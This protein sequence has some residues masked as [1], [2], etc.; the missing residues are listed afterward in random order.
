MPTKEENAKAFTLFSQFKDTHKGLNRTV[1]DKVLLVDGLNTF[2][3]C[4]S[5]NPMMNEDGLHTGGVAGFLKSVGYAIKFF[6]PTRCIIIFDGDGGSAVRR[7]IYPEYKMKRKS[8]VRLNRTYA[9]LSDKDSE[10]ASKA[11]QLIRLAEYLQHLPVNI[12]IADG[13]EADDTIAYCATEYFKD[14]MVI[15][16]SSD[17][18]FLQLVSERIKVWSPS[19]KTVYG[20]AEVLRDYGIHPA[21]FALFRAMDGDASDNIDGVKGAGL[22]TVIKYFPFMGEAEPRSVEYLVEY[23]QKA[24]GKYKIYEKIV[25]GAQIL[26]RNYKLMQLKESIASSISQMHINDCL[27][28]AKIPN[29]DRFAI[30]KL[31]TEDKMW[32]NLPNHQIWVNETFVGLDNIAKLHV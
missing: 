32:N 17:K 5:A 24:G 14:S 11:K 16:M 29:L 6:N 2:I 21:N 26:D 27:N 9:E 28:K 25:E 31:I 19:K 13:I 4:W 1:N 10:E 23:A 7:K 12:L 15:I 30:V 3:R 18:D 22:K 8:T 20:P